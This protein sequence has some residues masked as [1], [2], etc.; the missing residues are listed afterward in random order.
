MRVVHPEALDGVGGEC[1][2][3]VT[4]GGD[5][6]AC[7]DGEAFE[8]PRGRASTL[9]DAYGVDVADI[10]ASEETE[11]D[12]P[13]DDESDEEGEAEDD[14]EAVED[15][16]ILGDDVVPPGELIEAG[17]CP[18]CDEYEGEHVGQHASSAHPDEWAEYSE[19]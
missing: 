16:P 7:S 4:L 5:V 19:G 12:P 14:A 17:E 1:P 11:P 8:L 2:D 13:D 10:E 9:A 3:T 15:E 18:W 6:Y